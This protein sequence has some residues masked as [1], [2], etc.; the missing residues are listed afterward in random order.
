MKQLLGAMMALALGTATPVFAQSL[1]DLNIQLHGYATQGFLYTTN[2][3]ILTTTSSDGSPDWDE[4]VVNLSSQPM[5]KLRVAIQVRYELLGNY[6]NAITIDYAM[7]DYKRSDRFGVRFGKVKTPSGLF[8]ETQDIDPSY[9]W[10][11]LPQS[12]YPIPS[13][14]SILSHYGGVV[15]GAVRLG[16][17]LGKLEYRGWGG[18]RVIA[19]TDGYTLQL[20][21]AGFTQPNGI[22]GA[23]VGA[24]IHWLTPIPGLMIGASDSKNMQWQTQVTGANGALSGTQTVKPSNT[25]DYFAKYER[26][27]LM[28]AGEY[29]REPA[30]AYFTFTGLPLIPTGADFRGWYGMASYKLTDK[31]S[32]GVYHSQFFNHQTALGA[33]RYEKDWAISAR[34]DFNQFLYAKAEQ[35]FIDGNGIDFDTDLNPDGLKP[36][37]KL[38][39]LK[40][41]VSF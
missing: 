5:P 20:R 36:N 26:G 25:P 41:G 38:T 32:V 17:K 15:Y 24:A 16:D 33:S 9:L 13:R 1:D 27:K 40:V 10:S 14:N 21:E 35:H 22:S 11:L 2:N 31:L 28:A 30:E 4:A 37:T 19:A 8:N 3:N 7:A 39:L 18:E 23:N 34:Y 29:Q 6:S 12:V